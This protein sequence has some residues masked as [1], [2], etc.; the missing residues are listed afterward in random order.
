MR[1]MSVKRNQ[2]PFLDMTEKPKSAKYLQY[3]F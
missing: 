3:D 2:L 1:L